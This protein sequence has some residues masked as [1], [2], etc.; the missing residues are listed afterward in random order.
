MLKK[1]T[2]FLWTEDCQTDFES[3]RDSLLSP[4]ILKYPDF[5]ETIMLTTDAS[6]IACGA[7]L[8]QNF[9]GH[10]LP[11]ANASKA[12]NSAEMKKTDNIT[13]NDR[14]SLGYRSFQ[15]LSLRKKVHN[16]NR[17][18]SPCVPF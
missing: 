8:S 15:T 18:L 12:F 6:N 14:H 11:I 16:Q 2:T 1:N 7:V 13:G 4:P 17:S 10:D 3:L 9:D 5:S